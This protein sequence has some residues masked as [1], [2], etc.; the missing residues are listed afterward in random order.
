MKTWAVCEV[1]LE[2]YAQSV[3]SSDRFMPP[4]GGVI[5]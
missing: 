4:G 1:E 2:F 3:L 5:R